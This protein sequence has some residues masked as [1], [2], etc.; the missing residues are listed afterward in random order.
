[1]AGFLQQIGATLNA[2]DILRLV[3]IVILL[4]ISH[5]CLKAIYN[6]YFH[7]LRHIPGPPLWI[8]FPITRIVGMVQGKAEFQMREA[9][10]KYGEA[11][12]V[13]PDQLSFI[14]PQAWKDIYGHGHAEFP[15]SY[16]KGINMDTKKIISA[17]SSDHFRF[18]RA[19]L[20]AFSDKALGQQ[21]PLIKVYVDLLV[22]RL[23]EV[24]RTGQST[25]MVRWYNFT[26]FDLIADLAFG[27]PLQGLAEGKSNAWLENIAKLMRYMP[28]LV[29]I[30]F[31]P[32]LGLILKLVAGSKARNSQAAHHALVAK[33]VND[34]IY[35]RKQA[36][37]G[38]FMDYIMRSRGQ[39]H[40]LTDPELIA[41]SDLLVV[42]GSETT[43]TLL[44]GAT[45]WLLRT[46][47][48]L[49]RVTEEVRTAFQSEDEITFKDASSKLPYMIACL[50]EALRLFP[51]V[52]LRL[53]R[54]VPRGPPVQIAGLTV[55]EK[56]V[57]GVHHL[58]AYHSELNFHR[59]REFIP[60]RW[61]HESTSNPASPFYG[62]RRDVH[63][64]FSFGPR[65]CI[66]RNLAYHEMRLILA[67]VLWNFDLTLDQSIG[68]WEDQK[69]YSLWEKPPLKVFLRERKA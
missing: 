17:N 57:V 32:M 58:A 41:N 22:E 66:G 12:R 69:I 13:S 2:Y 59:A 30:G 8:A 15:K 45:Y 56:T 27:T 50:D 29:L 5:Q 23:R 63:R 47:Y 18:R 36:D 11:I 21:E 43:A 9:H 34:R 37:R 62:D 14:N 35:H 3:F 4:G 46:P 31:T 39:A 26:T 51:P 68:K 1:M 6:L 60:E 16:P 33:L 20:P 19:M 65:D 64:P 48:A 25:D 38:D 52:P 42:A 10:D 44:S 40:E 61:L 28:M 67:R 53:A 7:P 55:P 54:A 24:A 49:K